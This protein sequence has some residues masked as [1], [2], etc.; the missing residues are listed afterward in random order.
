MGEEVK[1]LGL[2]TSLYSCRVEIALKLK[3]IEYEFIEEDLSNKSPMLLRYNSV[4]KKVPVLV[5]N[6]RAIA[7]SLV[8]L[9]YIDETWK[10]TP[11]LPRDPYDRAMA[12]FWVNFI[13]EKG[14]KTKDEEVIEEAYGD[15][16]FLETEL[17]DKRFFGGESIGLV[18]IASQEV[19]LKMGEEV[20]LLGLKRSSYSCRVEIA[21]KLKGIGYEFIEEDL[22]NKSPML[23]EYNSVHK[24]VPVLVHNGRAIAESLV[25]LE[26]ID[27]TWKDTPILPRDPYDRAMAR[28]WVKFID[29]KACKTNDEEAIEEAY[30]DLE[31]LE[32]ALNDKRFFGGESIGLVDIVADF[33]G[34]WLGVI[35]EVR[36]VEL[37]KREKFP[38]LC[39]WIDEFLGC[40]IV[41]ESLP[42]REM[43]LAFFQARFQAANTST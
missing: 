12:R 3:G 17:N 40:S 34:F 29:E 18:D 28:F 31:F 14:I 9:E 10:D 2:K 27:E 13:D 1:L 20:K 22:S 21:L 23:L 41:K 39:G 25:I 26:Y 16:E 35:Q 24:K 42:S 36:G 8:I 4:H 6:G 15:L 37:L 11:I 7:E 43:L 19:L 5:H 32:T 30:G 33:I 38:K